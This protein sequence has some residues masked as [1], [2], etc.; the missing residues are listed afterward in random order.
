MQREFQRFRAETPQLAANLR[1]EP[2]DIHPLNEY[3]NYLTLLTA[4]LTEA[5]EHSAR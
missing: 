2:E 4:F 3:R 1:L 5:S